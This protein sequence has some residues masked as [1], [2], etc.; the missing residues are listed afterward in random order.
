[1]S[2]ALAKVMNKLC[3][4]VQVIMNKF[5]IIL[6][7][8]HHEGMLTFNLPVILANPELWSLHQQFVSTIR[9]ET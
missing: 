5:C 9:A 4:Y 2:F 1:M 8:F 7:S 6:G 3:N